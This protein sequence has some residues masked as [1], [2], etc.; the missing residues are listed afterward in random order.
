MNNNPLVS[1]ILA[2]YNREDYVV[3]SIESAL[4]QTYKN[5]QLI[6]I[7]DGSTDGTVEKIKEI[8]DDRIELYSLGKN[9]HISYA[10]NRGLEKVKGDYVA[11]LDSD[12]F[13]EP[14]KLKIQ[15]DYL[16]DHPEHSGCF[17][18]A[19]IV[20]KS[21]ENLNDKY[22][23][24][25]NMY[26][27]HTDS[28]EEWLRYF[29]FNGNRLS[30]PSSIITAESARIIGPHNLFY[31]QGQDMEWW[32]RFTKKYSFG[33]IEK[34]LVNMRVDGGNTS[35]YEIGLQDPKTIRFFNE[36]MMMRYH[37]FDDIDDDLFIRAFGK[38]FVCEDSHTEKEL[39]CEKA[40]LMWN[41]FG[42]WKSH[43]SIALMMFEEL[44]KD[45]ETAQL[46]RDK[47][48]FGTPELG[49]LTGENVYYD[50]WAEYTEKRCREHEHYIEHLTQEYMSQF[51]KVQEGLQR[52]SEL[53]LKIFR[54]ENEL[55]Y[56]N[57]Q[58][59]E[60]N[61]QM[62]EKNIQL[63]EIKDEL[64]KE[65]SELKKRKSDLQKIF[66]SSNMSIK[67]TVNEIK[68]KYL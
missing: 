18:W 66:N 34:P 39:E 23:D 9:Y 60:L 35:S 56:K 46:L 4:N 27:C 58:L 48:K 64:E 11:I 62:N 53:N 5:I 32:I 1:V 37:F 20:G 40:F 51:Q 30:N 63:Y 59:N 29:F 26:A 52:Q 55:N 16:A 7:D 61:A 38:D 50:A 3:Q 24:A 49:K 17:T 25:Y 42:G 47:Y 67:K 36:M 68:E 15:L 22:K 65:K 2:V 6:I 19:N 57:N 13:W 41:S 33:V 14:E 8:K 21:G 44:M 31:I 43:S 28:Q 12:D 10:T 54:M 45:P